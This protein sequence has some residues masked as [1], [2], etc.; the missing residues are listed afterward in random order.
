MAERPYTVVSCGISVDGY[1]DDASAD[2]LV[3]SNDADLDRV[4]AERAASDAV[5]VGAQTVRRDDPRLLV[6]STRRRAARTA[7]GLP[8]SPTRVT[9]TRTGGLDPC[10]R[11][12]TVGSTERLV[13]CATETMPTTSAGLARL[14]TVVDAGPQPS[15][16][17]V[18][19]D[20]A[21]R[22]I[23]RLLVEGGGHVI[24]QLL[25][26]DLV[27]E[28][29]LVIAPIFVGDTRAPRFVGDGAFPWHGDRRAVLAD[30]TPIGDVV[31][32]RYALSQRSVAQQ[33]EAA[34]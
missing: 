31:L 3:L 6:R 30:V 5:L 8:P 18:L 32:L 33:R 2:R 10:A 1:L 11:F 23:R 21:A 9:V 25:T 13:Y 34:R 7:Q 26:A 12:F 27:D 16:R 4:D 24:T 22:G 20:L 29:Q 14:A 17:W 15:L 28:L 19:E